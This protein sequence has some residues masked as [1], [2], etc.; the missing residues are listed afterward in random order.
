MTRLIFIRHGQSVANEQNRFAGQTDV[1]LTELGRAQAK[2]AAEYIV[3]REKIDKIYSSDLQRAHNTALPVSELTGIPIN[4]VKELREICAGVW[5]GRLANEIEIEYAE[6]FKTWRKDYSNARLPGGE[7]V[8]EVYERVV[9][10]VKM[11]AKENDGLTLLFA[12][13]ASPIRAVDCNSQGWG[14]QRMSDAPFVKNSA[15]SI[16]EYDPISDTISL[17]ERNITDH[18]DSSMT[19]NIPKGF[20][21]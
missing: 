1:P 19:T 21:N 15:I 7:S 14:W 6:E 16:F 9:P 4:D 13:H 8:Q 5:E 17:I 3:K 12:S 18:L 2:C 11:I 10:F 20:R